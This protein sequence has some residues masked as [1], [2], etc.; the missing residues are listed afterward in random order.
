M[1][2]WTA[3]G[4]AKNVIKLCQKVLVEVALGLLLVGCRGDQRAQV[5][6]EASGQEL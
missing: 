3:V 1:V 6:V 4:M 5:C 2:T